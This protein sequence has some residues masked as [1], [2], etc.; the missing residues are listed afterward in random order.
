[1]D[2]HGS[3]SENAGARWYPSGDPY[4][5]AGWPTPPREDPDADR[6]HVPV[7]R[8]RG[9]EDRGPSRTRHGYVPFDDAVAGSGGHFE[10]VRGDGAAGPDSRYTETGSR[11]DPAVP[12]DSSRTETVAVDPR[13]LDPRDA[14]LARGAQPPRTADPARGPEVPL[15][16]EVGNPIADD[17]GRFHT[18]PLDRSVLGWP[19]DVAAGPASPGSVVS[20]PPAG[21]LSGKV[22][23]TR[24]P[25]AA[26]LIIVVAAL[27]E[28]VALRVFVAGVFGTTGGVPGTVAGLFL[29]TGLPLS[30]VGL[31]GLATGAATAGRGAQPWL[32]TPLAYL[33]VGLVLL[34]GA[35]LAA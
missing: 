35:G 8:A 25:A 13:R 16:P 34:I 29:L 33:L 19:A 11:G 10:P 15:A 24:R 3:Y 22:Y 7:P 27:A 31:Y 4:A 12:P 26:A 9:R 5:E 2:G 6:Y 20:G 14:E 32:R 17:P 23:R 21:D 1:M 28:L 30:A 18:Q